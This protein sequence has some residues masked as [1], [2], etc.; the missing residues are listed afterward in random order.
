VQL[1]ASN[2]YDPEGTNGENDDKVP[3]A[4]DGNAS[5]SWET[6]HYKSVHFGGLKSGVGLVVDA[7]RRVKLRSLTVTS[8][9]PGFIADIKAG[10]SSSCCFDS[11]SKPQMVGART[12]F[13]LTMRYPHQVLPGLDRPAP[14]RVRPSSHQRG[15]SG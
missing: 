12:T 3:N 15:D 6:E 2:A 10:D 14:G 8:E 11:V 7:G 5:T 9:T 4:T 1:V 13:Q